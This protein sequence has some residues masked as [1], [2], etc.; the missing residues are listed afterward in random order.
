M[1]DPLQLIKN[2]GAFEQIN[3][4]IAMFFSV[5]VRRPEVMVCKR[6]SFVDTTPEILA[7][8]DFMR[9]TREFSFEESVRGHNQSMKLVDRGFQMTE[10]L[11]VERF[12][13]FEQLNL[14]MHLLKM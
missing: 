8:P 14:E 3:Y 5:L 10:F 9:V 7:N 4:K 13:N 12:R 1:R 11:F 6:H 2:K